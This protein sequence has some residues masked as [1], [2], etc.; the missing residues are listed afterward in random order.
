MIKKLLT[1]VLG[2]TL[3]TTSNF[4]SVSAQTNAVNDNTAAT[5]AKIKADALKLGTGKNH[6]VKVKMLSGIKITGDLSQIADDSLT[7]VDSKTRQP[8]EIAYR[9]VAQITG[10]G[11]GLPLGAKI[12]IGAAIAAGVTVAILFRIRYCNEQPCQ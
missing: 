4:A 10:A 6:R 2:F 8:I 1:F 7:L 3:L 9:N 12:G 11:G 5:T